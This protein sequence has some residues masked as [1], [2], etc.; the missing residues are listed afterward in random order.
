MKNRAELFSIFQKFHAEIQTQ[1]NVS[2]RVLRSDNAQEYF[3]T[4]FTSFMSQ[5][6]ILHQSSYAHTPQQSGVAKRKNQH[7]V[8][9]ARTILLHSHVPF[10]FLGGCYSYS[11]LLD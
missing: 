6:E 9:T 7:L 8:E 3:S 4:P 1:F 11:P 10:S 2:I 5:H